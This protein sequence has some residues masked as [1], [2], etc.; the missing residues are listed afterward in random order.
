M[1][2]N[3]IIYLFDH[4]LFELISVWGLHRLMEVHG[5]FV[6]Q[7]RPNQ[8]TNETHFTILMPGVAFDYGDAPDSYGTLFD[9]EG[10]R[11]VDS[12]NPLL[13][14]AGITT[15]ADGKPSAGADAD[16]DDGVDLS[17]S[18]FNTHVLTPIVISATGLGLIDAWID[19]NQDG[20][21]LD[22]GEQVITS[23][24]VSAGEN[25]LMVTTPA[26][27]ALGDTYARFRISRLGGLSPTGLATDGEVED[28]I[29]R[30]EPGLPPVAN[31]DA[32]FSTEEGVLLTI[33]QADLLAND[34]DPDTAHNLL[35]VRQFETTSVLGATISWDTVGNLVYDPTTST[36][37]QALKPWRS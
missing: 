27:A 8:A 2:L 13:L 9:S 19:F 11:H 12:A 7:L 28:Y 16:D 29:V 26:G 31:D 10:A 21:W 15:E 32:G 4:S 37:L 3:V 1:I 14:G 23:V 17:M 34:T 18:V 30:I 33:P 6:H 36:A 22:P 24:A 5:V 20:D 35:Q 25:E